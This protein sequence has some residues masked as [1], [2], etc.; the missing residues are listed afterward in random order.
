MAFQIPGF[1][2]SLDAAGDLSAEQHTFM[3]CDANGRAAQAGAGVDVVGALQ[4]DPSALG[5]AANIMATGISKVVAGAAVAAGAQVMSDSTGR[6][7]TATGTGAFV[8][9]VA[10]E[11]AANADEIIAVLLGQSAQLN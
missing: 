2:F 3:L 1:S 7:I 5:E 4:N 8:A 6:A 9:G 10:L 11:A